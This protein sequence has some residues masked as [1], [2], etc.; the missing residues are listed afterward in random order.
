VTHTKGFYEKQ[1]L[2]LIIK[3]STMKLAKFGCRSDWK[4]EKLKN[5]AIF[6]QPA[7][8]Y[9]LHVVMGLGFRVHKLIPLK[10]TFVLF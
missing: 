9:C 6:W 1:V 10:L 7:G 2:S 4:V 5:R 8:T 3:S